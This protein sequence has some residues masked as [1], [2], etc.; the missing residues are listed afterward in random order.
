MQLQDATCRMHCKCKSHLLQLLYSVSVV[1][2]QVA[3]GLLQCKLAW[4]FLALP[5]MLNTIEKQTK[6][7]MHCTL[8]FLC[9]QLRRVACSLESIFSTRGM[10]SF[11][12]HQLNHH[13]VIKKWQ[14]MKITSST[15]ENLPTMLL[16][17]SFQYMLKCLLYTVLLMVLERCGLIS[18]LF[19]IP[20]FWQLDAELQTSWSRTALPVVQQS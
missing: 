12:V 5:C 18:S 16:S 13:S 11:W 9:Y 8:H 17:V 14:N 10:R 15:K 1:M 20:R 6:K 7:T 3:S 2:L 19:F 4:A